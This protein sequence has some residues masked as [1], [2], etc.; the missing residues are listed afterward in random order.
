MAPNR[1]YG[2]QTLNIGDDLFAII[3]EDTRGDVIVLARVVEE[4][5]QFFFL[6]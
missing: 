3:I 1:W 2:H 4:F 6:V 5:D